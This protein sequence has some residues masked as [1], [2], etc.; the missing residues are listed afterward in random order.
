MINILPAISTAF[1]ICSIVAPGIM[2]F[3]LYKNRKNIKHISLRVIGTIFFFEA[4][5]F[6]DFI[7]RIRHRR[8]II[9]V[10]P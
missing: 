4:V 2:L 10:K 6:Y 1:S 5:L 8:D 9:Q 7:Q 3:K